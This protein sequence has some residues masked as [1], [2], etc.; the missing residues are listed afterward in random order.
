MTTEMAR[1]METCAEC[2]A[3][4]NLV[5]DVRIAGPSEET[6]SDINAAL[7]A[8]L[9]PVAPIAPASVFRILFA[10]I[11]AAMVAAGAWWL[12]PGG[13]NVQS[14]TQKSV[15]FL[16]LI[17]CAL[18]LTVA[19]PRQM[20]PGSWSGTTPAAWSAGLIA[21]LACGVWL[22][23]VRHP[24]AAFVGTGL[25]CLSTGLLFA[26]FAGIPLCL[27]LAR[28]AVLA[29]RVTGAI[30]GGFAGLVGLA[31]LE[32]H[33]SNLNGLHILVWHLATVSISIAGGLL[34]GAW[35]DLKQ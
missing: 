11:I 21:V 18:L 34:I 27:V 22:A 23:F 8:D 7:L 15:V 33:C 20:V 24:E 13:W 25:V 1:H 9:K 17:G 29:P 5:G 3:M 31:V 35:Q 30:T 2:R 14:A 26:A 19:I 10:V 28:G 4:A 16:P 6:L 12:G 32:V